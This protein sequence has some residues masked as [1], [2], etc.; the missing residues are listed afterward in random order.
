VGAG[1]KCL[2]MPTHVMPV[3]DTGIQTADRSGR[4]LDAPVKPGHDGFP[5]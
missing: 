5:G 3:P 4:L 2:L 1:I